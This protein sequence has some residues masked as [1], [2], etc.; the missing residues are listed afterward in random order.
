MAHLKIT[1]WRRKKLTGCLRYWPHK[2]LK[3][4][5]W[6]INPVSSVAIWL[7][8]CLPGSY[9]IFVITCAQWSGGEKCTF[10]SKMTFLTPELDTT[11]HKLVSREH[12]VG[13]WWYGW[14][15]CTVVWHAD[16]GF[17]FFFIFACGS[18][19]SWGPQALEWQFSPPTHPPDNL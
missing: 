14:V 6:A 19:R 4:T 16:V 9:R 5:Y 1:F 8:W 17:S 3:S 11:P 7:F 12:S 10:F 2:G 13:V 15:W 18:Q